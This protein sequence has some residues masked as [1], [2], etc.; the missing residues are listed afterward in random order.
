MKKFL[1]LLLA[2]VISMPCLAQQMRP[3]L[4]KDEDGYTN[5]R[6]GPGT[7]YA[8]VEQVPDG[9]FINFAKGTNGW[10][11]VYTN[12]TDGTPQD[13]IGY[14][15]ANK[16]VVPP[17]KGPMKEVAMVKDED[18]YTNIRKGPSTRHAIVGKVRDGSYI[19]IS[20]DFEDRWYKVYTQKGVFRGYISANKVERLE[21]PQF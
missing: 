14:M 18:G 6:K 16:I 11:K 20:G 10:C 9:M 7:Q 8:I 3:G 21:S 1:P 5:I 17:R 12:Y 13:L 4:V 2:F 15:S 19:L